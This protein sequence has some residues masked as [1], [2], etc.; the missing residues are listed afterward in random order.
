MSDD[1]RKNDQRSEVE[2]SFDFGRLGESLNK[3]FTSLV[4]DEE[5]RREHF[6][7]PLGSARA[8]RIDLSF[9]V[10]RSSVRALPSGS[11]L[12]LLADVE[13]IEE[14]DF[15]ALEGE[16][17]S[18]KLQPRPTKGVNLAPL[19]QSL[20]ALVRRDDLHWDCQL[21][22]RVPL[23]L[24][25]S[26]GIGQVIADLSSLQLKRLEVDGSVGALELVLPVQELPYA[27]DIDSGV[28]EIKVT[29]PNGAFVTLDIDGGVGETTITIPHETPL[30]VRAEAGI[31]NLNLP[32]TL[33]RIRGGEGFVGASGIWQSVGFDLAERRV[34]VHYDGGVGEL[35]VRYPQV[36]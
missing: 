12:L 28:G 26:M 3:L 8:A 6:E 35:N 16:I 20:R 14:V 23:D 22:S 36:V 17:A 9:S 4:G 25:L 2:W 21:S 27:V 30:Q 15:V 19:R 29:V 34:V 31:G 10:G 32:K 11:P 24:H 18:V 5:L 1:K 7:A 13:T 33:E